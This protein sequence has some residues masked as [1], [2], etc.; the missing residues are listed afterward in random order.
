MRGF[1]IDH[2]TDLRINFNGAPVNQ[3]SHGHGQGYSDLNFLIPELIG[4][5]RYTKGP[6]FAEQGDFASAGSVSFD[7]V[8]VLPDGL[9]LIGVGEDD[10]G[11]LVVADTPKLGA[12][13]FLYGLEVVHN[14]GPWSNPDNFRK[15]DATTRPI[16]ASGT[17]PSS[18]RNWA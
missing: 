8:D 13:H 3:R 5:L 7:Y 9:A 1:N 4:D 2:G 11:R 15:I 14:D 10:Y 18:P 6:Y 16:P 12:G 17:T